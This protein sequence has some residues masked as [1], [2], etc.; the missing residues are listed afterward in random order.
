MLRARWLAGA[1]L[2]QCYVWG[3]RGVRGVARQHTGCLFRP[4]R[5]GDCSIQHQRHST[6]SRVSA[7]LIGALGGSLA[8]SSWPRR[9]LLR[10]AD[11]FHPLFTRS[12]SWRLTLRPRSK[13]RSWLREP[14]GSLLPR[15]TTSSPEGGRAVAFRWRISQRAGASRVVGLTG[16]AKWMP[17][18]ASV[19]SRAA[20]SRS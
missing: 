5:N 7:I 3:G 15:F 17:M 2:R 9:C 8:H 12:W 13:T 10:S 14:V 6:C 1:T 16:V 4:H 18:A 19:P 11:A 20:T